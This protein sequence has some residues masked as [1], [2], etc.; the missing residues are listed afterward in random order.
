M[1]AS[2][3]HAQLFAIR[4]HGEIGQLR[5]YTGEPYVVHPATVAEIVRSVPHTEE[6]L[7]AAWLHD[8]V[9]DT[10]TTI[11]QIRDLFGEEVAKMVWQLTK[12]ARSELTR[13]QRN[14]AYRASLAEASPAV[15]TIKLADIIDNTRDI[16]AM[17]HASPAFAR[18]YLDE[19]RQDIKVLTC[20]DPELITWAEHLTHERHVSIMRSV[21]RFVSQHLHAKS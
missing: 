20:G 12:P 19:K 4:C 3:F 18:Q 21:T 16:R 11:D 2:E 9:E 17:T 7:C 1:Q 14:V 6:M 13:A 5:K 8:V 15:Q 10:P